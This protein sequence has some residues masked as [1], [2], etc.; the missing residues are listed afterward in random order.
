MLHHSTRVV[1]SVVPAGIVR[2]SSPLTIET[3]YVLAP[4]DELECLLSGTLQTPQVRITALLDEFGQPLER[5]NPN[6]L[7]RLETEP[8]LAELEPNTLLRKKLS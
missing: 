4:G 7:A 3:R 8:M 6:R 1:Q 2:A 5:A